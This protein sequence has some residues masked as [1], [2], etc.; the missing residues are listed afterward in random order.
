M[1][2]FNK[3]AP[4]LKSK[5]TLTLLGFVVWL[6]FFDHND[7]LTQFERR[8]ELHQLEKGKE[9]YHEQIEGI[10]KDLSE[11]D[12]NPASLEKAAREKFMMKRDDEELFIIEEK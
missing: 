4:W 7:I 1:Q 6:L 10:R 11:L 2:L 8:S 3:I 12:N 5:Y 9:Y